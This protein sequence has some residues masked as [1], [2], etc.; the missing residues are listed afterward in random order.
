MTLALTTVTPAAP[1]EASPTPGTSSANAT[2]G[3]QWTTSANK[4]RLLPPT[5]CILQNLSLEMIEAG[6]GA[7]RQD[8]LRPAAEVQW[9]AVVARPG[10][11]VQRGAVVGFGQQGYRVS[12]RGVTPDRASRGRR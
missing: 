6:K 12:G 7:M 11:E 8:K 1:C 4:V 2:T 10:T 3:H 5:Q 9:G